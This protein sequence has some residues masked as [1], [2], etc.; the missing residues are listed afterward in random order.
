[1]I[2]FQTPL[3]FLL[4]LIL[5]IL[6][7]LRLRKKN[8]AALRF[9][10]LDILASSKPS[11][12]IRL[13]PVLFALRILCLLLL[14][15]A[16]ARPRHGTKKTVIATEGIAI[17]LVVDCSGSMADPM[18]Y[19]GTQATKLEAVKKVVGEF[20]K[21]DSDQLKGRPG[22][23]IG[24]ITYATYPETLCPLVHSHD[25]LLEFLKNAQPIQH[26][27]LGN[28]AIGDALALASSRLYTAETE[29][30]NQTK[31]HASK[32][33][34][35]EAADTFKIKSKV[36]ILLTDGLQ[37][38]GQY[39]P[40]DAAELAKKWDIKIYAIGVASDMYQ[41]TF[42]GRQLI[43]ASQQIN[44]PLLNAVAQAT[45]GKYFHAENAQ[46][47]KQIY[48]TIDSLE[49]STVES[50]QYTQY[51]EKFAP[52]ANTA[53]VILVLEILASSTILRKIP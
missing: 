9:S 33:L 22:D 17:E 21:G 15:I 3:A 24:L 19:F 46:A 5:P 36:I 11:W 34:S 27:Q 13:R 7:W 26:R 1:M 20:V 28:T 14:I 4:V 40:M 42:F 49:K 8:T 38:A 39:Q 50:V 45:G 48:E 47:L 41:D 18:D 16:L 32:T 52:F 6:I 29:L 53:L 25:I 43:P 51:A 35:D 12:R 31:K 37:N 30:K 44:E 23:L 10:S 2:E